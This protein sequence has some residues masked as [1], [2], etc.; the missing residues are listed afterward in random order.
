MGEEAGGPPRPML[1][2]PDGFRSGNMTLVGHI[3][4]PIYDVHEASVTDGAIGKFLYTAAFDNYSGYLFI[5]TFWKDRYA[6]LILPQSGG[7]AS[8]FFYVDAET[9]ELIGYFSP[10]R[11]CVG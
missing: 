5:K 3:G 4:Y 7:R 1:A 2:G 11:M 10:C 9:G 8:D 6:W